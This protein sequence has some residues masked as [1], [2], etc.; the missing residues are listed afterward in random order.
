MNHPA[1][2]TGKAPAPLYLPRL[3]EPPRPDHA[4]AGIFVRPAFLWSA[5]RFGYWLRDEDTT[6]TAIGFL[7]W[8][9]FAYSLKFVWAPLLD[10]TACPCSACW[11]TAAAGCC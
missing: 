7:S 10:R 5:T 6:L 1:P 8:V 9:G 3:S 4:G 11:A 2:V